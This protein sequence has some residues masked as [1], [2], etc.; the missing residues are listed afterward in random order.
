LFR[1][2]LFLFLVAI[3]PAAFCSPAEQP[4]LEVRLQT[5]LTSYAS[6][7]GSPFRCIVIR[8]LEIN[9]RVIIPERSIVYGTVSR[10]LSVGLG[11][12]RERA[13]LELSFT[14]YETP[15]GLEFPLVAKL[16]SIDNAREQVNDKG[17]IRG[18]LAASSP[19]QFVFGLW[20]RPS[21]NLLYRSLV[22]LTGASNQIW[23]K[24][25]MGAAGAGA[26]LVARCFIF[27]FPEPEIHLPPGT[28]MMLTVSMPA[29]SSDS[30]R[31]TISFPPLPPA[32]P[33]HGLTEWL[34][35][36]PYEVARPNGRPAGDL[37]NLA[38]VGSRQELLHAFSAA[39][40][41]LADPPTVRSFSR[42]YRAFSCMRSYATAPVSRLLYQSVEPQMVFEKSLNT[43]AKRHHVRIWNGGLLEGQQIW[44]AAATH[45]TGIAFN[46]RTLRP[47]HKIDPN[48]DEEREKVSTDLSFAG[49]SQAA[50]YVQRP[51]ASRSDGGDGTVVT[52]GVLTVLPLTACEYRPVLDEEPAPRPP[53]NKFTRLTRRVVLETRNYLLRDN[54]Y[55]WGYQLVRRMVP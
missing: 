49:C 54:A 17:Q 34:Q 18:I 53:G 16:D 47:T 28:D 6:P 23:A 25:S 48:I 12:R 1:G 21:L 10:E 39:G 33:P 2:A 27:R 3:V 55:Y 15:D 9:G 4:N 30:L 8:P 46:L 13:G 20:Q 50:H 26:L 31:T 35:D 37:I 11:F 41:S 24:Y 44:L 42:V 29:G 14:G 38:F 22:G 52:D 5:H 32:E 36:K 19:S 51:N 43:V 40:W 7:R 45:D